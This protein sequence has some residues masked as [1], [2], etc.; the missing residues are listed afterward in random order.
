MQLPP[1]WQGLRQRALT[2]VPLGTR[3]EFGRPYA[4]TQ[5]RDNGSY[6]VTNI[7]PRRIHL[8]ASRDEVAGVLL[9]DAEYH[10]DHAAEHQACLW[11]ELQSQRWR[12][13]A[14]FIVTSYYWAFF[15]AMAAT[16]LLGRTVWYLDRGSQE[17][18]DPFERSIK[19]SR[20]R[21][22]SV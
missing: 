2:T 8:A 21:D 11:H 9:T 7:S 15:L 20:S 12:S 6:I 14:W 1:A 22:V 3:V 13:P 17:L 10:L 18:S 4:L 19:G 5:W 16:R